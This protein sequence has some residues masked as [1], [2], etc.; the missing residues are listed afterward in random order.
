MSALHA[1]RVASR[2]FRASLLSPTDEGSLLYLDDALLVVGE[3]G[4]IERVEAWSEVPVDAPFVHDLRPALIVPGFVDTHLHYPQTRII[5][6]ATGP[7]LEW[8][9]RSVF[10]EEARFVEP[11]Y[12]RAV[13]LELVEACLSHGTTTA[14]LYSSSDPGAAVALFEALDEAGLRAVAGPA[15]MDRACPDALAVPV[16]RAEACVRELVER[17]HQKGDRRLSVAVVPRFALSCTRPML[18]MATR[19]ADE[20]ALVVMTHIAEHPREGVETL[21]VH[22]YASDYLGV[23]EAT[24]LVGPR[25]VL[26]HAIHLSDGEWARVAEASVKIAH[27]PD[28]NAFLGSGRMRIDEAK[29]RGVTV[30]LGSD[31]AAGRSFDLRRAMGYAY[32]TGLSLGAALEVE[33]LFELA[34]LGGARVLGLDRQVGSL[35]PGKQADFVALRRPAWAEGREGAL[36]IASFASELAPVERCYV[37]GRE[38]WRVPNLA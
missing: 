25:T 35:E 8:L 29:R 34:T 17:F 21:S 18:E 33:E 14:G 1:P 37:Q 26:A 12:A 20:H 6:S 24:G 16:Q 3:E 19:I 30:G 10:P 9:E 32:D 28:S 22:P 36:R 5:G 11:S 23:Y 7:L 4:T 31:V 13:A 38:V 15:L 2:S 27:C